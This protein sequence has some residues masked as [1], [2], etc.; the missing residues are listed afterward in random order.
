MAWAGQP[1]CNF[2]DWNILVTRVGE[3]SHVTHSWLYMPLIADAL[4]SPA[5]AKEAFPFH[6]P[7]GWRTLV[8]LVRQ[9]AAAA[10]PPIIAADLKLDDNSHL[11]AALQNQVLAWPLGEAVAQAVSHIA[12]SYA[13]GQRVSIARTIAQAQAHWEEAIQGEQQYQSSKSSSVGAAT[14]MMLHKPSQ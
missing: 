7:S 1:P 3:T 10:N 5:R 6:R 2:T 11:P 9:G 13:T 8:D 14:N 12:T 4:L